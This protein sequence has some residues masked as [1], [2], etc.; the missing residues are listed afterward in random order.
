MKK[1][2][3]SFLLAVCLLLSMIPAAGAASAGTVE[4]TP[5]TRGEALAAIWQAEGSP[6]PASAEIPFTDLDG[7]PYQ[8][9]VAWAVERGITNGVSATLFA[10]DDPVTRTQIAA[11]LYRA[12][13]EPD[14]SGE[15]AWYADALHWALRNIAVF[16]S[17]LP[18]STSGDDTCTRESLDALLERRA[19]ASEAEGGIYILYTSDVHCGIDRGFGYAGLSEIRAGLEA[20]GYATILVDDGDSVQGE[21]I[22]TLSKGEALIDLMNAVHYDLAIPGNHEFEYGMEQFMKFAETAAFPYLSCN[23]RKNGELVFAPYRILEAGGRKIGFVGVTTP[24]T[25]TTADA[26][27]FVND[28]GES[29]YDFLNDATGEMLYTGVQDAVDAA[30]AEGADL[31]YVLGH[32]GNEANASPWNYADVIAHTTGID[33]FFDG[34]SHDTDQVTMKNAAGDTVVR[35]ACGTKLSSV[36]YSRITADGKVAEVGIWSWS[37]STAAPEVYAIRNEVRDAVDAAEAEV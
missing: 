9:A 13:G 18:Q 29:L 24:W 12:A 7:S 33:V 3:L 6:A 4:E 16:G 32:L 15:G 23:F 35:S 10:P 11:F 2:F 1:R 28:V 22:G 14:K 37:N 19:D 17:A 25:M 34:H 31:V 27:L 30:R 5:L 8:S 36:G 21:S 26:H 20:A